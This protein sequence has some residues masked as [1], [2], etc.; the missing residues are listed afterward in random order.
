V[1]RAVRTALTRI[2]DVKSLV[3]VDDAAS[4]GGRAWLPLRQR[5]V[6]VRLIRGLNF[7]ADA[8][9]QRNLVANEDTTIAT[10]SPRHEDDARFVSDEGPAGRSSAPA[11][12]CVRDGPSPRRVRRAGPGSAVTP[13]CLT[14]ECS[15]C[16]ERS[17]VEAPVP[18]VRAR[19]AA[20]ELLLRESLGRAPQAEETPAV[21]MPESA[22]AIASMSWRDMQQLAATLFIDELV[23]V[24]RDGGETLL[25]ERVAG[26]G[27]EKRRVLREALA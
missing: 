24:Q 12:T 3:F 22:A 26:L 1:L 21:R 19:V 4:D 23:T 16:G 10:P 2:I 27:D 11:R 5:R 15:G 13:V 20:I 9:S 8:V 7:D 18:D 6:G 17:R 25:R 14:V